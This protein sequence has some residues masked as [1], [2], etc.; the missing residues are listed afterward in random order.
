VA[1]ALRRTRGQRAIKELG[2]NCIT[3]YLIQI[4]GELL[5]RWPEADHEM[6]EIDL[7]L[8]EPSS[9]LRRERVESALNDGHPGLAQHIQMFG[10]H[11]GS[12]PN[13]ARNFR[14]HQWLARGKFF[15]DG[16]TRKVAD[17]QKHLLQWEERRSA[18]FGRIA[19]GVFKHGEAMEGFGEA[20][21]ALGEANGTRDEA[22]GELGEAVDVLGEAMRGLDDPVCGLDEANGIL[23]EAIGAGNESIRGRH[24]AVGVWE[25]TVG[26]PDESAGTSVE[27]IHY[28]ATLARFALVSGTHRHLPRCSS[29]FV[30]YSYL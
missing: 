26:V 23:D 29:Q 17:R 20:I 24:E 13:P 2:A 15:Q 3:P 6:A 19:H 16:P 8:A 5:R 30:T 25:E 11:V 7:A 1:R 27:A 14:G 9:K 22:I 21:G 4:R 28:A 18:R 10:D 12:A